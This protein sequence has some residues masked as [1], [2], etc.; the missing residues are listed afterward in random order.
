MAVISSVVGDGPGDR[1]STKPAAIV[2]L[3]GTLA[4]PAAALRPPTA[5]VTGGLSDGLRS[6][7]SW[8]ESAS[9]VL[10]GYSQEH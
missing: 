7:A 5:R 9:N 2:R 6:Q 3:A 8:C 4:H 1:R 10:I